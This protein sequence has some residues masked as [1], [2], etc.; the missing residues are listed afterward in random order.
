M[1]VFL[2]FI[3]GKPICIYTFL[4]TLAAPV[5]L[6]PVH[7]PHKNNK[8]LNSL[9]RKSKRLKRQKTLKKRCILDLHPKPPKHLKS[10]ASLK[11]GSDKMMYYSCFGIEANILKMCVLKQPRSCRSPVSPLPSST[12]DASNATRPI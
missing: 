8:L 9:K 1:C 11:F 3:W 2:V 12:I 5:L 7:L 10:I 6:L 4:K